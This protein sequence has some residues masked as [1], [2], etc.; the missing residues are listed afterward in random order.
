MKRSGMNFF[1][2]LCGS[3]ICDGH[4]CEGIQSV[5]ATDV[6]YECGICGALIILSYVG[7]SGSMLIDI[8]AWRRAHVSEKAVPPDSNAEPDACVSIEY[9]Q[10]PLYKAAVFL[11]RATS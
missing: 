4:D 7:I 5:A 2:P 8:Q 11:N 3:K 9:E 6:E 10:H 1:C